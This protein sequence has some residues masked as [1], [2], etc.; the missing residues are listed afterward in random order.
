MAE[1]VQP[2]P[3]CTVELFKGHTDAVNSVHCSADGAAM[4]SGSDDRTVR[5]W[6]VRTR[7]AVKVFVGCFAEEVRGP[8]ATIAVNASLK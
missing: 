5:L 8:K 3:A 4:V 2:G 1:A 6:D 7:R